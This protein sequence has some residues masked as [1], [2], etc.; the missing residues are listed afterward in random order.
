ARVQ[1]PPAEPPHLVG[2]GRTGGTAEPALVHGPAGDAAHLR[3]H[4]VH[5]Y[6]ARG[7][8]AAASHVDRAGQL[9]TSGLP[10]SRSGSA[11]G[12]AGDRPR[13]GVALQRTFPPPG[14]HAGV[15]PLRT[16]AALAAP[17][18]VPACSPTTAAGPPALAVPP[19]AVPSHPTEPAPSDTP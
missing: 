1:S 12:G 18:A 9:G 10:A 3:A 6:L 4:R 13:R 8:P 14:Y 19:T 11:P 15:R 17:L 7:R 5:R 2:R 16:G